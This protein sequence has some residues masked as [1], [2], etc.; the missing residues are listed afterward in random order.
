MRFLVCSW[1]KFSEFKRLNFYAPNL[2]KF[3]C[4]SMAYEAGLRGGTY[5][6]VLNASNELAVS[7]FLKGRIRFTD[8]PRVISKVLC[9]HRGSRDPGLKDILKADAWARE[10]TKEILSAIHG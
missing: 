5:P 7:E 10:K 1:V 4:L 2:K 8:I 3:P 9:L 6:C